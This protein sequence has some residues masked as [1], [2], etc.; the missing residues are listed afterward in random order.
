MRQVWEGEPK[1]V[2]GMPRK[3]RKRCP[4]CS[5]CVRKR[6]GGIYQCVNEECDFY[7]AVWNGVFLE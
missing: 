1:L 3:P 4:H 7:S 5:K 6:E 2:R